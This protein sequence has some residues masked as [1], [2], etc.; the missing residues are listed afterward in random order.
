MT[1]YATHSQASA[2]ILGRGVAQAR[3]HVLGMLQE[4]H[5]LVKEAFD[6]FALQMK[7]SEPDL[8]IC[9]TLVRQT[10]M[11]LTLHARLEE[12]VFYPAV[13]EV[14][15]QDRMLDEARV[16]H[17]VMNK[18]IEQLQC[19]TP[20]SERFAPTFKVLGEY[21]MQHVQEEE[22]VLFGKL[23]KLKLNWVQLLEVLQEEREKIIEE[24]Q[25]DLA[26]DLDDDDDEPHA[27]LAREPHSKSGRARRGVAQ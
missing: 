11:E 8:S 1:A 20:E 12:E 27:R 16:E 3:Q 5:L 24:M 2:R 15:A 10:C 19:M 6:E 9:E 14:I 18:L 4:D 21:V 13:R 17:E 25:A 7:A 23:M 26:L 22:G